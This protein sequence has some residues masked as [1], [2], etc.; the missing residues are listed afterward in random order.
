M[1][2]VLAQLGVTGNGNGKERYTQE[3]VRKIILMKAA[4][5]TID[6]IVAEVGHTPASIQNMLTVQLTKEASF[7]KRTG[8]TLEEAA[9]EIQKVK[10]IAEAS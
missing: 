1:A 2:S 9:A 7:V 6:D 10:R 8:W 5:A 3:Q 4:G